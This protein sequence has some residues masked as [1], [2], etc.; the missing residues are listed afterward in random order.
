MTTSPQRLQRSW[1][2]FVGTAGLLLGLL[3]WL[4]VRIV[5]LE[6]DERSA[7]AR[8]A[9][10]QNLRL[11]LWRM[12][13]WLAPRLAREAMRPVDEY[14]AFAPPQEAWTRGFDKLGPDEVL[15]PSPLLS[16]A[17]ELF[18]LHFEIDRQG[19]VSSPQVPTGNERDVAEASGR[20]SSSFEP[21]AQRL[22]TLR[23]RLPFAVLT[24]ELRLAEA[25]LQAIGSCLVP[26]ETM[27]PEQQQAAEFDNRKVNYA[28]NIGQRRLVDSQ[29]VAPPMAGD[30]AVAAGVPPTVGPLMPIWLPGEAP[31][32]VFLRRVAASPPRIQGVLADWATLQAELLALVGDLFPAGTARLERCEAAEPLHQGLLLASV[33]AR[34]VV[35]TAPVDGAETDFAGQLLWLVWA[36]ALLALATFGFTLRAALGYGER[37]ARFASAVTHEL[38]TPLTTFR[39]Y[40]EMLADGVVREPVAQRE[41]LETLRQESDRLSR[42]VENVLAWSRLEQGRFASRREPVQVADLLD[43]LRPVLSRR[44]ADAGGELVV[45]ATPA[46]AAAVLATDEDAVGQILFNLVDNAAKYARDAADR[47]VHLEAEIADGTLLLRV[48][49]HG[50]GIPAALQKRIFAPFD[51]GAVPLASNDQPGV[52][53]GLALA[54][55]LATDLGGALRLAPGAGGATFELRLP[56]VGT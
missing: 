54:R 17:S 23:E 15:V 36:G 50:P 10:E 28:A 41:Y 42:V 40:S 24:E 14:R 22:A 8:T 18:P 44:L 49:D 56:L 19:R 3:A 39:M 43:R 20:A 16:G 31:M 32:L 7:R 46:A 45:T 27:A 21:A 53:L 38:R 51:R 34:L 35:A 30:V 9:A 26:N 25:N 52:G 55:G 1:W 6:H 33:P 29:G 48:R 2:W 4:S 11:A 13:S 5:R 37:R 12:D 47:R